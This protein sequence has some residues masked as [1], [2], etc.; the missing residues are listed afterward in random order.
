MGNRSKS[1][2]I[3]I[4]FILLTLITGCGASSSSQNGTIK[5]L[6]QIDALG[7]TI[8]IPTKAPQR[9]IS[10]A[11]TETEILGVLN[12]DNR[13]IAVDA[14]S[15][16]PDSLASK[17]KVTDFNST[18]AIEQIVALKPDL[19]LSYGGGYAEAERK[20][21]QLGLV[22]YDMPAGDLTLSLTEIKVVGQL[23]HETDKAGALVDQMNARINAVKQKVAGKNVPSVY[24]EVDY[25]TPG[26]PFVAGSKSFGDELISIAGGKN[27]FSDTNSTNGGYPQVGDE[28]VIS[29]NPQVIILTEDPNYGGKVENVYARTSWANVAAVKDK[30]IYAVFPDIVQ[31]PGPRI[32]QGLEEVAR[33]IHPEL[34]GSK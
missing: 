7:N 9:I 26:K 23:T 20:L 31:R 24:M 8:N 25:F 30:R 32:V 14:Y 12:I 18:V 15:N 5:S 34:F 1:L 33:A 11:T 19:I 29:R 6:I 2:V 21:I 27:I 17:P 22:V 4:I 10:L 3:S 13:V 16:Y 28:T